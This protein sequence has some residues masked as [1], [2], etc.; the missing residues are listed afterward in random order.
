MTI[1]KNILLV[2][3]EIMITKSLQKLLKKEGFNAITSQ[4]GQEAIEKIKTQHFDLIVSDVN[5][6]QMDGIELIENIRA[7]L[8]AQSKPPVPEILI[9]GYV[10]EEK[11]KYAAE[12]KPADYIY[13]PF[14]RSHFLETVKRNLNAA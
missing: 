9:T 13:K 12:L 7:Y 2:D 10:N 3:D 14:D 1:A 5:M 4:T 8:K 11:Y 6:P